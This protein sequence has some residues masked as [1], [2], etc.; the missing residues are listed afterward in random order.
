M[1][2]VLLSFAVL[3]CV[4][5]LSAPANPDQKTISGTLRAIGPNT[6]SLELNH[7]VTVIHITSGTEIWR[8]G[9]DLASPAQLVLGENLYAGYTETAKDGLPI[10]RVVAATEQDDSIALVPHHIVEHRGCGGLAET[11]SGDVISVKNDAGRCALRVNAKT[12]IWRGQVFHN[13]SAVKPGDGVVSRAVVDYVHGELI[14]EEIWA[15]ISAT[16][17]D[18]VAV[19]PNR[20]IVN[21]YPGADPNSAYPRGHLTV[22]L[23]RNTAFEDCTREDLKTGRG[24]RAEGL[25]QRDGSLLASAIHV[26]Q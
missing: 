21:Q 6:I 22:I 12:N 14:A 18:I 10:A 2:A 16:E 24:I 15:D 26:Y 1:R 9:Q 5:S 17:G 11:I 8:R 3:A 19:R 4:S 25:E 23:N 7:K 13:A 20:V